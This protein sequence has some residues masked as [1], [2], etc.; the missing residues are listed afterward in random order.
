VTPPALD[1]ASVQA[2]LRLLR[3]LLDDLDAV[4]ELTVGRLEEDRLLRYAV[5]RILTQVVDLAVAVNGHVVAARTGAAPATYRESFGL[6]AQSGFLEQR[7]AERLAPS[8]GLRNVLTHEYVEVDLE[9]VVRGV[10]LTRT[11]YREYAR[12]VAV[13]LRAQA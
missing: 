8:A 5:E 3:Q 12:Q 6:L 9:L 10:E 2:K 4:G 1:R 11:D 7:L 13:A